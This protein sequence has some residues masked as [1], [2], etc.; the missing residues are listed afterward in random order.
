MG[1]HLSGVVACRRGGSGGAVELR[2]GD[3]SPVNVGGFRW[4][5]STRR[6]GGR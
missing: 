6:G 1:T 3:G 4:S 2:D 5:Y